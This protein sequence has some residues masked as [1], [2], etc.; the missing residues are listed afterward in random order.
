MHVLGDEGRGCLTLLHSPDGS[1]I[2]MHLNP[3]HLSN[4]ELYFI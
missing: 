4:H 3:Q 1:C 2:V